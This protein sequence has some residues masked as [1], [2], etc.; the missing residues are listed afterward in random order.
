MNSFQ[1][2]TESLVFF[3]IAPFSNADYEIPGLQLHFA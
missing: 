2:M 3:K 1:T